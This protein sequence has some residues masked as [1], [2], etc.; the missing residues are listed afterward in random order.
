MLPDR[1]KLTFFFKLCSVGYC[2]EKFLVYFFTIFPD[3]RIRIPEFPGA[4]LLIQKTRKLNSVMSQDFSFACVSYSRVIEE[5][6]A[7]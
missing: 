1:R 3:T 2:P 6:N 4:V 5:P 7:S